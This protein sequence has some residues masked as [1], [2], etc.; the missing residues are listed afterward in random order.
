M[1]TLSFIKPDSL[2][3]QL[4]L[5]ISGNNENIIDTEQ[6]FVKNG[7]IL[8]S[9]IDDI[10]CIYFDGNSYLSI[11]PLSTE[12]QFLTNKQWTIT[13]KIYF[14]KTISTTSDQLEGILCSEEPN[15]YGA[16]FLYR[17]I[18]G[19]T[20]NVQNTL[21]IGVNEQ[22]EYTTT[23]NSILENQWLSIIIE[24]NYP[25]VR[26][27]INDTWYTEGT[28]NNLKDAL[29]LYLPGG[30]PKFKGGISNFRLYTRLLTENEMK[31]I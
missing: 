23:K 7:N 16:F 5:Y 22:N 10:P 28:N 3:N 31:R 13:F 9:N 26:I 17:Y 1:F 4:A 11:N 19:W 12:F 14:E 29:T 8:L 27:K 18:K 24:K 25:N 21:G 20:D 2:L 6:T 30:S 15:R